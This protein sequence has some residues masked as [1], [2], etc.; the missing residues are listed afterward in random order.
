LCLCILIV[1][2]LRLLHVLISLLLTIPP[3]FLF[4]LLLF[5][6]WT[7]FLL[8][9]DLFLKC[10]LVLLILFFLIFLL[11]Y[12]ILFSLHL[13]LLFLFLLLIFYFFFFH[14]HNCVFRVLKGYEC[15]GQKLLLV[16]SSNAANSMKQKLNNF[17]TKPVITHDPEPVNFAPDPSNLVPARNMVSRRAEQD[18]FKALLIS[19]IK[20]H[21]ARE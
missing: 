20:F 4:S 13:F 18:Y 19:K 5:I 21:T 1:S 16:C 11:F 7:F 3:S 6:F 17:L 14:S 9:C 10:F 2:V 12:L 15:N 8:F